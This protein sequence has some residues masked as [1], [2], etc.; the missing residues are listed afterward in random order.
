MQHAGE[1]VECCI[2]PAREE[3]AHA[4]VELL[5]PLIRAGTYTIMDEPLSVIDQ[6]DFIRGFPGRGVYNVAVCNDSHEILGIQDV[7][8]I[9]ARTHALEH[10]GEVSTFVSLAFHR[11]RIGSR[12][13]RATFSEARQRGFLKLRATIRA[14]NPQAM[15]F[16]QSQGFKVVG[17]AMNAFVGGR[18]IDEVVAERVLD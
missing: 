16:Y 6:V 13:S 9:S 4:I 5:N 2:R 17:T 11:N 18:Y 3:D 10:V 12:L 14:D 15:A 1:D 8:P 7:Q